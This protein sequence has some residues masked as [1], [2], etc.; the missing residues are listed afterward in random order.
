MTTGLSV[1]MAQIT[2]AE[3]NVFQVFLGGVIQPASCFNT[4]AWVAGQVRADHV[5]AMCRRRA[6]HVLADAGRVLTVC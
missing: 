1:S 3:G 5:L 6:G 4:S 2:K